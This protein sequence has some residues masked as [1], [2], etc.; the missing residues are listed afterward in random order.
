MFVYLEPYLRLQKVLGWIVRLNNI[1]QNFK[2][3]FI[4][5]THL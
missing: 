1:I 4:E 5:T 3:K 2:K